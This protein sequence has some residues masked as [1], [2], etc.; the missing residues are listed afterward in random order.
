DALEAAARG[1]DPYASYRAAV[2]ERRR[3]DRRAES[4]AALVLGAQHPEARRK[5]A[6]SNDLDLHGAASIGGRGE[7]VHRHLR[8][9]RREDRP[10]VDGC[11]L[12]RDEEELVFRHGGRHLEARSRAVSPRDSGGIGLCT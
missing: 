3:L 10:L 4:L 9:S 8:E 11:R 5:T 12:V 1:G 2:L 6:A 7:G